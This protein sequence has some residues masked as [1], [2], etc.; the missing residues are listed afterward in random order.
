MAIPGREFGLVA[1]DHD[2]AIAALTS[3]D[4]DDT[5]GGCFDARAGR[6][7]VIDAFVRAPRLQHWDESVRS[8]KPEVMRENS[9]GE[10]RNCLR[11]FL[12]SAV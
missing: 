8:L 11:K 9:S 2:V 7:A 4:I 5:V 3:R 10:R 6:R 12:P 1:Q